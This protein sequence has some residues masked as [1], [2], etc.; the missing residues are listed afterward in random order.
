M[1]PTYL[2]YG[3]MGVMWGRPDGVRIDIECKVAEAHMECPISYPYCSGFGS[4]IG[5][6]SV[7][8]RTTKTKMR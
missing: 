3:V 7:C 2:Q 1:K 6:T 8:I 4:Q 5:V